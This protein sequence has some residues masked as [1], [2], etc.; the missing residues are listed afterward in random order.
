ML[1]YVDQR[2][3]FLYVSRREAGTWIVPVKAA[4]GVPEN[5]V[6]FAS[7]VVPLYVR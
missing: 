4:I 2:V 6:V 3:A 1:A 7:A 5:A